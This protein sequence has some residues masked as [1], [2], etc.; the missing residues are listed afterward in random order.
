MYDPSGVSAVLPLSANC[1][2]E[3][4]TPPS[5]VEVSFVHARPIATLN[6]IN[7]GEIGCKKK[8]N[9]SIKL[10]LKKKKLVTLLTTNEPHTTAK[11]SSGASC[12]PK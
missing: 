5:F 1:M 4:A 7:C 11:A 8:K 3:D 10:N 2:S 6:M 9:Q 12:F